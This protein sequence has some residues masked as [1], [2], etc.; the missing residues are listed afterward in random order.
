MDKLS[1]F[2]NKTF[3]EKYAPAE[4]ATE[5]EVD[6][7][8]FEQH[9]FMKAAAQAGE[10]NEHLMYGGVGGATLGLGGG[11]VLEP[12]LLRRGIDKSLKAQGYPNVDVRQTGFRHINV[13]GGEF[14]SRNEFN[15]FINAA[16]KAVRDGRAYR[17]RAV[18]GLGAAGALT[19]LG[20]A[21]LHNH[22]KKKQANL[23]TFVQPGA[24]MTA[25]ELGA[26]L[27]MQTKARGAQQLANALGHKPLPAGG[28]PFGLKK[29]NVLPP[30]AWLGT[31]K[32]AAFQEDKPYYVPAL[33]PGGNAL[34][35]A[36]RGQKTK[37]TGEG[38]V[39]GLVGG[40]AGGSAGGALAGIPLAL[41][42][43]KRPQLFEGRMGVP[44][45][46]GIPALGTTVGGALGT[47][48][49]TRGMLPENTKEAAIGN[50]AVSPFRMWLGRNIDKAHVATPELVERL[51]GFAQRELPH[52]KGHVFVDGVENAQYDMLNKIVR[53]PADDAALYAHEL[54]HASIDKSRLG[55]LVQNP[56]TTLA[57][58]A[59][60]P[61]A[62][63]GGMSS[64]YS[65][66]D[67]GTNK[68]KRDAAIGAA[69]MLPQLA[70]EAEASRRGAKMLRNVGADEAIMKSYRNRIGNAWGTYA[71]TPVAAGINYGLGRAAGRWMAK[72]DRKAREKQ[73]AAL[74]HV[75]KMKKGC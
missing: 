1:A 26:A 33:L 48:M 35:G 51:R 20:A 66:E 42:A 69:A 65:D 47:H 40:M 21:A 57:G 27:R 32:A 18:L 8:P 9:F 22:Y 17:N 23:A 31:A 28:N 19:G 49:A 10:S 55:R 44:L 37:R 72:S 63:V 60:V 61:S 71:L 75:R 45:A 16:G 5:E 39:R 54:G 24:K 4:Q 56:L 74:E 52:I 50:A 68:V 11:M 3:D 12:K 7:T 64:G 62:F 38:A 14:A 13:D 59:A 25:Q 53:A 6:P 2:L 70:Y 29:P 58:Q 41:L 43:L 15:K 46:V 36:L 30:P 67:K 73:A 34:V